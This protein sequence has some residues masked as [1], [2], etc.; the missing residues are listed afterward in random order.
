[1]DRK[2]HA[3]RLLA[4]LI[5][6]GAFSIALLRAAHTETDLPERLYC[7]ALAGSLAVFLAVLLGR[8]GSGF[9]V[10]GA[11]T[12]SLWLAGALKMAYLHEPLL[13]QDLVYFS[14]GST[15]EVIAHYA[16][17]RNKCIAALAGGLL[18]GW[19][20]WRLESPGW[21]RAG[22]KRL[23]ACVG[24]AMP[25]LALAW[26]QGPFRNVHAVNTWAY[27][28]QAHRNPMATFLLSFERMHVAPPAYAP[29]EAAAFDW[30]AEADVTPTQRR[31]DLV[32]VLEESTLDPRQ[33]AACTAPRCTLPLF[34]PDPA[35]A[36]FGALRVHTYGGATWTSEFAFLTGMPHTLF[37]PAGI[38]APYN[39]APRMRQSLPRQLSALG[40]RTIALY[41]TSR[42]FVRAGDAYAD[43]G[44]DAFYDVEDL[45]F[46]GM[47]NV[48]D[49][50]M[51]RAAQNVLERERTAAAERPLFVM[52]LTMRQHGPHDAPIDDLPP[53]WNEP[54]APTL[55]ET[56]NRALGNYLYRADQSSQA[57]AELRRTL[58]E[59]GRPVALAHF[60]DHH[61]AFDG[62][63]ETLQPAL[64][65]GVSDGRSLT[66][67]RIDSNYGAKAAAYQ[68]LDLAFLGSLLLDVAGLPKNA[69][70]EANAR[71]RERCGGRYHDCPQPALLASYFAYVFGTLQAF[72][73]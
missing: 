4:A 45:G 9:L 3:L 12:G 41:P 58:F 49:L 16:A 22:R 59:S 40:Y 34:E 73:R 32:V 1:M 29:A 47:W 26:P 57:I 18:L 56:A 30:G 55:D 14:T 69:Y 71:L 17:L 23:A 42:H 25:L 46:D 2:T 60:G 8:I 68:P 31:P 50:D 10:A 6:I 21:W 51:V 11:V 20:V 35:T 66:Y 24:A 33:W 53:P 61:P 44:F 27:I 48:G 5:G 62:I 36:A 15:F 64:P 39:L 7:M 38:Y 13:A 28:E 19:L 65:P 43:Y 72:A 63:E 52:M 70:F 67:Y 54:P 37:G